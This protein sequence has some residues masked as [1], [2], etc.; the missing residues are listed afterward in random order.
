VLASHQSA[1]FSPFAATGHTSTPL[2]NKTFAH[3]N[4]K[5]AVL[6]LKINHGQTLT[7]MQTQGYTTFCQ[8]THGASGALHIFRPSHACKK[9]C[10]GQRL[11]SGSGGLRGTSDLQ[12]LGDGGAPGGPRPQLL[13]GGQL[14]SLPPPCPG[15]QMRWRHL[16]MKQ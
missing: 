7:P 8:E 14:S 3:K 5:R 10:S 11:G 9:A 15:A 13:P 16:H 2:P 1:C 4:P 6:C 12:A